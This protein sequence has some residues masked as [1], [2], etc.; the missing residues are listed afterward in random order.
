MGALT[1]AA[2]EV[3]EWIRVAGPPIA[4]ESG[5]LVALPNGDLLVFARDTCERYVTATGTW[6]IAGHLNALND[7]EDAALLVD[8]TVPAIGRGSPAG[9]A[10]EA[11]SETST[12][13]RVSGAR[14]AGSS[15]LERAPGSAVS[16]PARYWSRAGETRAVRSWLRPSRTIQHRRDERA[17]GG[18]RAK[19]PGSAGDDLHL[20]DRRATGR[21]VSPVVERLTTSAS[22]RGVQAFGVFIVARESVAQ[23]LAAHRVSLVFR[24]LAGVVRGRTSVAVTTG[25]T[26]VRERWRAGSCSR[27]KRCDVGSCGFPGAAR[28]RASGRLHH[29]GGLTGPV[30]AAGCRGGQRRRRC[31]WAEANASWPQQRRRTAH[32]NSP[33]AARSVRSGGGQIWGQVGA[34]RSRST[35]HHSDLP[36]P[37]RPVSSPVWMLLILLS[38]LR[39]GIRNQ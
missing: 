25:V 27:S 21:C 39:T 13:G 23:D 12:P 26:A 30:I 35:A 36:S 16:G 4:P 8:G 7:V 11:S 32:R 31:G 34:K 9:A 3:G 33:G 14:R 18:R 24:D 5:P 6:I 28:V 19:R 20:R 10:P 37:A 29:D 22:A 38:C 17:R 2:A 15:S 1:I